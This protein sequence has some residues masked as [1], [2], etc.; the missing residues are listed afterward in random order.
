M[1]REYRYKN[2][3]NNNI[4][5]QTKATRKTRSGITNSYA[6]TNIHPF[7][8]T[9]SHFRIREVIFAGLAAFEVIVESV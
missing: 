4:K 8:T 5:I 9:H 7:K 1:K 3:N 6:T 2:N